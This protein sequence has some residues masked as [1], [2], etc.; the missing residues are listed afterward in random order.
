MREEMA[1]RRLPLRGNLMDLTTWL[2][3]G[4][5]VLLTANL[6]ILWL[7]YGHWREVVRDNRDRHEAL[8]KLLLANFSDALE[9]IRGTDRGKREGVADD[10]PAGDGPPSQ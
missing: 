1:A 7:W 4:V 2:L 8:I 9:A 6:A 5:L 10:L 3:V